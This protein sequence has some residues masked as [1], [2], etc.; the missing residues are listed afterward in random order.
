MAGSLPLVP[1]LKRRGAWVKSN[2]VG[3]LWHGCAAAGRQAP[4]HG[5][6]W[7]LQAGG[8]LR[9][10]LQK[11]WGE[12]DRVGPYAHQLQGCGR[13]LTAAERSSPRLQQQAPVVKG[14]VCVFEQLAGR[15]AAA[16]ARCWVNAAAVCP[17]MAA[18]ASASCEACCQAPAAFAQPPL[19]LLAD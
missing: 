5:V 15:P 12:H 14:R 1:G 6:L 17:W 4:G 3:L 2:S 19:Q 18:L 16:A 7:V 8:G 9:E 13:C 11:K 10:W